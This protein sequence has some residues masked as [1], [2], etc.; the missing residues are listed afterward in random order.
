M[1]LIKII[2]ISFFCTYTFANNYVAPSVQDYYSDVTKAVNA[3]NWKDVVYYTR[4][5]NTQYPKNN[6]SQDI[7]FYLGEA[8]FHMND[9][10][11]AN[12]NF[13]K[14]L[15]QEFSPKFYEKAIFYK[16]EIA[17]KFYEGGKKHL[18][19][20]KKL[21]KWASGKEDAQKIFDEVISSLPNHEICAESLFYKGKL[22]KDFE[23]YKESVETFQT[24]IRKFP[25]HEFA[26]ESF[27]EIGKV[28]LKQADPKKQDP[29]LLDMAE[30]NL[31]KF[32]EVFPKEE[33]IALAEK[34]FAQIKEIYAQG[35]FEIGQF[36]ERTKKPDASKIYY[37][38]IIS[39]FP[40]TLKAELSQKRL[41]ILEKKK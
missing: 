21:P 10:V 35:L 32:K 16:F 8:Y 30:V 4:L 39:A 23:D 26:I 1:Q 14:Y 38:K 27:L 29:D 34:D 25:K 15:V 41:L 24:L 13:S 28:Y 3:K 22:Q 20:V 18:L 19:G 31:R 11:L 7:T 12:E 37:K 40:N 17:K 2:L 9:L 36:Y 33:R 5:I 6:F